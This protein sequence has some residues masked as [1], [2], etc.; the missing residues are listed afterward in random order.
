MTVL[1]K[2]LGRLFRQRRGAAAIEFAFVSVPLVLLAVGTVDFG[3]T[4]FAQNS[5]SYAADVGARLI[6]LDNT[7]A[8]TD[9]EAAVTEAFSGGPEAGLNV[10]LGTASESGTNFRTI[11][12]TYEVDLLTPF[13]IPGE[14]V[15]SHDRRVP[16][17]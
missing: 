6:F 1:G 17:E 4:L 7:V 5:L 10:A 2:R 11:Q 14:I 16:L 3:R 9:V 13:V 12:L 15:L 8:D